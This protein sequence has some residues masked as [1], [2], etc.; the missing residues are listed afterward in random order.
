[1]TLEELLQSDELNQYV[2]ATELITETRLARK[3]IDY[4]HACREFMRQSM[5]NLWAMQAAKNGR[6]WVYFNC[7]TNW[8]QHLNNGDQHNPYL[9]VL[10]EMFPAFQIRL[11]T[12]PTYPEPRI[13][14]AWPVE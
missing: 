14:F 7:P 10:R 6:N 1:M 3:N 9:K 11:G 2:C 12:P 5:F 8:V 13:F 4:V